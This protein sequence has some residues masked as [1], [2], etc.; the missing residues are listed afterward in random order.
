MEWKEAKPVSFIESL[1]MSSLIFCLVL[2]L[3]LLT[4]FVF[5][6]PFFWLF[7]AAYLFDRQLLEKM[8]REEIYF[9]KNW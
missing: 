6:I 2:A 9:S 3:T 4:I 8:L 7:L 5:I 1:K